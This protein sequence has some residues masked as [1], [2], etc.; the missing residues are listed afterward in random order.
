MDYCEW[1]NIGMTDGDTHHYAPIILSGNSYYY[2]LNYSLE[3]C[4]IRSYRQLNMYFLLQYKLFIRQKWCKRSS[5]SN[6]VVTI[7]GLRN[8][9]CLS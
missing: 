3:L 2:S 9:D 6:R 1:W 4:Q 7:K 5:Y 8:I